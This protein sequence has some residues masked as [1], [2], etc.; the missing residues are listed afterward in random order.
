VDATGFETF[1][2]R[3]YA[4]LFASVPALAVGSIAAFMLKDRLSGEAVS[5][6]LEPAAGA[7]DITPDLAAARTADFAGR[8]SHP[9]LAA[10]LDDALNSW[11][12]ADPSSLR[13]DEELAFVG[14]MLAAMAEGIEH[15]PLA[16]P[17]LAGAAARLVPEAVESAVDEAAAPRRWTGLTERACRAATE[18]LRPLALST[19][20]RAATWDLAGQV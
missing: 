8:S 18:V 4:E 10:T 9:T 17:R 16:Y 5:G 12:G 6:L 13:P 3:D 15:D 14:V 1:V 19:L 2:H 7:A 20:V 11:L